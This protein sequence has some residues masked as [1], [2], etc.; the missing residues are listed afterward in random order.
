M[1]AP[2][3]VMLGTGALGAASAAAK[4][5]TVDVLPFVPVTP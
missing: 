4:S 3:V 2:S 1:N 5:P